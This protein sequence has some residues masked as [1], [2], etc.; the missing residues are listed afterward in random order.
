MSGAKRVELITEIG[1][2]RGSKVLTYICSDRSGAAAQIGDDAVRPMYDVVQAIGKV[3]KIDLYL[4][5]RG[6][7]VEVPWRIITMLREYGKR[8]SVLIPY[9]AHSAATLIALGGDEIVMGSKAE[10]GPIDP[11][12]NRINQDSGTP[13]QEE[14]RVEDIMSYIGFLKDKAGL[15]DQSA[16]ATNVGILG[17]KL[18]P[19]VLGSIYRTHSH[20]RMV[21]RK[22]LGCHVSRIDEQKMSLIVE[23]LAEK[24]YLHGHAIGRAEAEDLGLPIV[25]PDDAL[26]D[27]MWTLMVEYESAMDMRNPI[28]AEALLGDALDEWEDQLLMALI[29]SSTE[30]WG[31]RAKLKLKKVR[32]AP[33]Q[34]A[35]NLNLN[36][37]LPAGIDPQLVPQ[38]IVRQLVEQVQRSVP[39]IVVEQVK[40]QSPILRIDGHFLVGN[41][42]ENPTPAEAPAQVAS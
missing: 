32:Q 27:L 6:G 33:P 29:E 34:I 41:W 25:K 4:Y 31:F 24:T 9:R 18:P 12:L 40:Q 28:N 5:S 1:R 10:L 42:V 19:W 2:A 36:V 8:V 38:E 14:I 21:A 26:E 23:S 39:Q 17:Q 22:L 35:V 15:G 20:I 11:A 16:L 3:P 37:G 7:A 13:V 30:S